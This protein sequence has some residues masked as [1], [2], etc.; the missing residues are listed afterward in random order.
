MTEPEILSPAQ[1]AILA[2]LPALVRDGFVLGGGTALAAR[3]LRHRFSDDLDFFSLS[4]EEPAVFS[5]LHRVLSELFRVVSA[6][7]LGDRCQFVLDERG[8]PVKLEAVPLYF[9]RLAVPH[10]WEGVWVESLEDLA[11][12]KVLA[13][14]DR[15][16][17]KDFVDVYFLVQ[18]TGWTL[19]DLIVLARRKQPAAYEYSLRLSRLA[20]APDALEAIRFVRPVE[21]GT[22]LEFFA[23]EEQSLARQREDAL[24][25]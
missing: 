25:R 14:V 12:N 8:A 23:N 24:R 16:D 20:A 10:R 17:P 7:R 11:A 2:R 15:F 21:P 18:D 3:Y 22:I 6:Q 9:D 19:A 4:R 1:H 5:V 13:L